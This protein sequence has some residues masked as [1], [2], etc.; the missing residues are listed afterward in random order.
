M[1]FQDYSERFPLLLLRYELVHAEMLPTKQAIIIVL[2]SP[3]SPRP[4]LAPLTDGRRRWRGTNVS[5]HLP[6]PPPNNVLVSL[7]D[8]L[9]TLPFASVLSN[10]LPCMMVLLVGRLRLRRH[11]WAVAF[12][13]ITN[14]KISASLIWLPFP[15]LRWENYLIKGQAPLHSHAFSLSGNTAIA[16][17][18]GMMGELALS[19]P[20]G[21]LVGWVNNNINRG[22]DDWVL[23]R[24][25]SLSHTPHKP[26]T[27]GSALWFGTEGNTFQGVPTVF[28]F[29]YVLMLHL[30]IH[31]YNKTMSERI[32]SYRRPIKHPNTYGDCTVHLQR[33]YGLHCRL[34]RFLAQT[35]LG[36]EIFWW[37]GWRVSDFCVVGRRQ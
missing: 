14:W 9:G 32:R 23:I 31:S 6:L 37:D 35:T 30:Y 25:N 29:P 21:A 10:Q 13:K 11:T 28:A 22:N 19:P 26:K 34:S 27:S 17:F 8:S 24:L 5:V 1:L 16:S 15:T 7:H 20:C 36:D 18:V 12:K 3:P 2:L 4:P 33:L